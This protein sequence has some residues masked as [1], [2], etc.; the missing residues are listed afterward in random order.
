VHAELGFGSFHEYA[1]RLFGHSPRLTLEKLRVAEALEALDETAREL[2]AGRI[3]FSAVRELSRV[4][5]AETEQEWLEAARGRTV[6]EIETMVSGHRPGSRPDDAPDPGEKRHVL[7]LHARRRRFL[8][9]FGGLFGIATTGG[10]G[11][12]AV[13]TRSLSTFI[14]ATGAW[15]GAGTWSRI[16]S[17]CALLITGGFTWESFSSRVRRPGFGSFT[18]TGPSTAALSV[19]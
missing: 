3:S 18:P 7:S 19:R 1:E 17:P 13:A 2:E 14:T 4:A 10:A 12:R 11:Y 8:R 16:S 9:L 15:T 5:T 6:R